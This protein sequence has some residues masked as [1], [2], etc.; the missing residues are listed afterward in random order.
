MFR[1]LP[2]VGEVRACPER[3]K[4]PA[5]PAMG[6]FARLEKGDQNEA[7]SPTL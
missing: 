7:C 5:L 4:R 1:F 6:A 3:Q 2:S